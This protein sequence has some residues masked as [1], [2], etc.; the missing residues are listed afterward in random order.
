MQ[1]RCTEPHVMM[2]SAGQLLGLHS[3]RPADLLKPLERRA[4]GGGAGD[5]PLYRP[6]ELVFRLWPAVI[7]RLH[8]R[9]KELR[10]LL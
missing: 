5:N 10:S 7:H 3:I 9:D 6:R 8:V 1:L 2:L 4:R